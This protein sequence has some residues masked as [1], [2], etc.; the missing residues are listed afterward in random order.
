MAFS[1]RYEPP[2]GDGDKIFV[3]DIDAIVVGRDP[4]TGGV[5]LLPFDETISASAARITQQ[6][7]GL[8]IENTSSFGGV[9][10]L[11]DQGTRWL[12]PGD[13]TTTSKLSTLRVSGVVYRH[14]VALIP[15]NIR[16]H[17]QP[18]TGTRPALVTNY[19]VAEERF[20]SLVALCAPLFYPDR[21]GADLLSARDIAAKVSAQDTQQKITQR[22]VHNK[23]Q[24]LRE[25]IEKRFG[26][27]L[28]TREDLAYWA[29]RNGVI[30][31][32]DVDSL[33]GI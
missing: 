9:E 17:Q 12:P 15:S 26:V 7:N 2:E 1:V 5:C 11:L 30:T 6:E 25:D 13:A 18:S 16:G 21:F 8:R 29:V 28:E 20:P 14:S 4:G 31:R 10:V 24:R 32:R 22:A 23:L 3:D 27:P 19:K 33:L